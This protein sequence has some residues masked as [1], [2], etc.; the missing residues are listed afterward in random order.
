MKIDN[1]EEV[2]KTTETSEN[3]SLWKRLT[4][5]I[6]RLS[7]LDIDTSYET[8]INSIKKDIE[9]KGANVWILFFAIIIASVGLNVNSTAVIIGAMLIS[10]LMGPINGVG[11][12]IGINDSDLLKNSL[13]NFLVMVVISLIASTAYFLISPLS[14]AQSELLARTNPTIYDVLIALFGGF[15][16]IVAASRKENKIVIIS[17]VAIATALMPPLCTAGYG[18]A[19]GQFNY[20]LGAF[21]LFFI[22][23]FFIALATFIMVRYLHFPQKEYLDPARQKVVKRYITVFSIIVIV[24]SVFMAWNMIRETRFNSQ[25]IKYVNEIQKEE[26]FNEVEI[27]NVKRNYTP[28]EQGIAIS[29]VGKPLN[30]EQI[31]RLQNRL[32]DFSLT[33][34][35]LSIKQT[36]G[37]LDLDMQA[38]V[39]SNL[40]DKKDEV[41]YEKDVKIHQLEKELDDIK[42]SGIDNKQLAREIAIQYPN[43]KRFSISNRSIYADIE[44]I[45]LDT[46]PTLYVEWINRKDT[47]RERSLNE[48]LK[49][50]LGIDELK[51]IEIQ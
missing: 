40:L 37:T 15:S 41:I 51:I 42:L 28:K 30:K 16:G 47:A 49:V 43:V 31:E 2:N 9:F 13:R 44:T 7:N 21:Y 8:T 45:S 23:S 29:L 50:R 5:Y 38:N 10:P 3:P 27:I 20:F 46:I 32:V 24:P 11:L 17:G 35:K 1:E 14:D 34:T 39:L 6:K 26:M 22:N 25:A 18:L 33:N 19:T 4:L 36:S 48:W 12:S